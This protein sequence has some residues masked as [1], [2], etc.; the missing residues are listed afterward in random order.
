MDS[1]HNKGGKKKLKKNRLLSYAIIALV[2]VIVAVNIWN[3][4]AKKERAE[5]ANSKEAAAFENIPGTK[6][7]SLDVGTKA[8]DFKLSAMTGEKVKLSD[9]RGKKVIL[10]FWA[11][12]CPPCKAEMP[13]M[14]SFYK[15]NKDKGIT[16]LAVNLTS[17]DK[18]KDEVQ[19]FL[20]DNGLTFPILL[21]ETG[22]IGTKYQAFTIPTSYI[23]DTKGVIQKKMVG[24]MDE[25]TMKG[26][27]DSIN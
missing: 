7:T 16:I 18:G 3:T 25:A 8:P 9:Y 23:I 6:I 10:N 24:P 21:D 14:E 20:N 26:F 2:V 15:A 19:K 13:H 4:A 22:M 11:T 12:W 27:T 5:E 1:L 17:M